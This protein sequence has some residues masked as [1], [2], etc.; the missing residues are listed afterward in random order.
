LR[1]CL[2]TPPGVVAGE[3]LHCDRLE[4]H[5]DKIKHRNYKTGFSWWGAK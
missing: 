5:T 4:G 3:Q 2:A 1:K